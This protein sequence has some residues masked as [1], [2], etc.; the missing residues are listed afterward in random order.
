MHALFYGFSLERHVSDGHLR[1]KIDRFVD[2]SGTE[3]APTTAVLY[4]SD[5]HVRH[6]R[7]RAQTAALIVAITAVRSRRPRF[8]NTQ[9]VDCSLP[10]RAV[11]ESSAQR[12][13]ANSLC[14][15]NNRR[16]V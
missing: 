2:L 11:K 6:I 16:V 4:P 14:N 12:R 1:R 5:A 13:T 3:G 7:R 15:P 8:F 9:F 10:V